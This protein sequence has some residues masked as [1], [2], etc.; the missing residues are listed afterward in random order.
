[1]SGHHVAIRTPSLEKGKEFY[2][3]KLDPGRRGVV[4]F[5]MADRY[6]VA[7]LRPLLPEPVFA[8]RQPY[9]SP[10]RNVR[11]ARNA[12]SSRQGG[13]SPGWC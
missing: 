9:P 3:G 1:M 12:P 2:D 13:D 11:K 6:M 7:V 5:G 8:V 10:E 4:A